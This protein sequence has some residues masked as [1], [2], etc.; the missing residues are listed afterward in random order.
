[1]SDESPA[2]VAIEP[3]DHLARHVGW[4]SDGRQFLLTNPFVPADAGT[5]GCDYVALFLFDAAGALVEAWVDRLG[6]RALLP[7]DEPGRTVERRLETLGTIERRRV[8]VAPFSVERFGTTFGL[9]AIAPGDEAD[10]WSV[11]L[12]PGR[13][14]TFF[15]PWDSGAYDAG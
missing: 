2:L 15:A 8:Q 4:T 5:E 9:V 6:P 11:E 3:D 14:M 7:A 12:Q 13:A 1:M 10:D